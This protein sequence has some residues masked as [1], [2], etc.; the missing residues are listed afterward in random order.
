MSGVRTASLLALLTLS[1]TGAIAATVPNRVEM[2]VSVEARGITVGEGHDVF[3]HDGKRY[4]VSTTARTAGIA[5]LL[6]N[7]E[8]KRESR[9]AIT[10]AGLR[11]QSF[12][13]QRTGK[14]PN[15]ASF[16][17]ERKELTMDEGGQIEKVA[18]VPNTFDQTSLAYAFV[19][20]EPPRGGTLHVNVTDGRKLSAY[21]VVLVG[22]E[23]LE[24][25]L[26]TL[27]TLHFRKVQPPDDKRG[28]EFWLSL[29]HFR[30]PIRIRIVE[31]DG[32]AFDSNV[33]KISYP[34]R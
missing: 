34:G 24:T 11:P 25:P 22:R 8:E 32:T 18:L 28:F 15:K 1:A 13:Q 3:E 2:D 27:D 10:D 4:S 14:A 12:Q 20:V 26:G 5:R 29:D 33:T 16:D 30:L 9:G 17:W 21:D 6:K 7:V 23:K 31:K 19:F